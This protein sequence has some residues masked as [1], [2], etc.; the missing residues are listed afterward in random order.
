MGDPFFLMKK[1]IYCGKEYPDDVGP[2]CPTD[3]KP[4][5]TFTVDPPA[6]PI[7]PNV[8][9]TSP[10]VQVVVKD[11]EMSLVPWLCS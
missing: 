5:V 3:G 6:L 8:G 4:L 10:V 11:F 1:C 7:I 9:V 2:A